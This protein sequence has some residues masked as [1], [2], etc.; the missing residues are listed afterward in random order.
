MVTVRAVG[1]QYSLIRTDDVGGSIQAKRTGPADRWV[2]NLSDPKRSTSDPTEPSRQR[3][4][5]DLSE[6]FS[7]A[8]HSIG[9]GDQYG[10]GILG[11]QYHQRVSTRWSLGGG[12]GI[13][14]A[15]DLGAALQAR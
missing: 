12:L 15:E 4:P 3:T 10:G 9:M 14:P 5:V 2:S 13:T 7:N 6:F 8:V 1:G 11:Y